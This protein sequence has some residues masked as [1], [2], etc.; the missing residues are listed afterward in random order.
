MTNDQLTLEEKVDKLLVY[1]KKAQF[2]ARVRAI[3]SIT[4]FVIFIVIP[5]I[6]SFY[7]FRKLFSGVDTSFLQPAFQNAVAPANIEAI[8]ELFN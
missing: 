2:W 8:K 5:V 3:I 6:W 1:Q 4:L 7:F